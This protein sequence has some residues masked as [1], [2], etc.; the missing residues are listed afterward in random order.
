MGRRVVYI[1]IFVLSILVFAVFFSGCPDL[2]LK[3]LVEDRVFGAEAV[4][5]EFAWDGANWQ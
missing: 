5:D 4:W 1:I 3:N 2:P